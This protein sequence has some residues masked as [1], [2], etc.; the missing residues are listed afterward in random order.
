[1]SLSVICITRNEEQNIEACLRS[2]EWAD[3]IIVV[4]SGS[5]DTTV[6]L[7]K[8]STSKVY[9]RP[10]E[11]YGSAKNFALSQCTMEWVLSIDADERITDDLRE[12]ISS[13]VLK[14]SRIYDAYSVPRKAYFLGKWIKHCGWYPAR[15]TRLFR[16]T[17]GSFS[18]LHVHESLR[19]SGNIGDLRSDLLHFTDPNLF[20]YFEKLNKY[21][22]LATKDMTRSGKRFTLFAMLVKPIWTFVRMFFLRLGFLDGLHGFILSVLSAGYVFTKYAKLWQVQELLI[23]EKDI[24]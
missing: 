1:M 13:I 23:P 12:E 15:I 4:D 16:R 21:T 2:V 17:A 6:E 20:H 19:I 3:E 5:V 8:R 7:A 14:N 18:E 11:G 9:V 24:V 22:T 10:W